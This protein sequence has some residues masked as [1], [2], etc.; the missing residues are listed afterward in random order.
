MPKNMPGAGSFLA[1]ATV[2]NVAAKDGLTIGIGA[3]T[4]ALDEKLGTPGVR[5][6]IAEIELDRPRRLA[7]QHGVP[8][9]H[10]AGEDLR[11]R[12]EDR[13]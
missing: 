1:L 5:F 13:I 10:L 9:A 11:R 3:P 12:A 4:S 8:L 7:H 6:K 2:Y